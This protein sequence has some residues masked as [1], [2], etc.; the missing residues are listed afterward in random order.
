MDKPSRRERPPGLQED[1]SHFKCAALRGPHVILNHAVRLSHVEA[2]ACEGGFRLCGEEDSDDDGDADGCGLPMWRISMSREAASSI[3]AGTYSQ[4]VEVE[5]AK[6]LEG[7]V[8][9]DCLLRRSEHSLLIRAGSVVV[10]SGWHWAAVALQTDE[11]DM[12]NVVAFDTS[13]GEALH[14]EPIV[15]APQCLGEEQTVSMFAEMNWLVVKT[16]S[17]VCTLKRATDHTTFHKVHSFDQGEHFAASPRVQ[18]IL[19]NDDALVAGANRVRLFRLED[20]EEEWAIQTRHPITSV[21][22]SNGVVAVAS[23]PTEWIK[24]R[25]TL[26]EV[27]NP[28]RPPSAIIDLMDAGSGECFQRINLRQ[29]TWATSGFGA[30]LQVALKDQRSKARNRAE[31]PFGQ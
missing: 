24:T 7:A 18:I 4:K 27:L 6:N 13:S 12:I 11:W 19:H 5:Y 15:A 16:R 3:G 1:I 9:A 23:S 20:W 17:Q 30:G 8:G 2:D 25:L 21:S 14:T 29:L 10:S 26:A 31:H 28:N 22:C